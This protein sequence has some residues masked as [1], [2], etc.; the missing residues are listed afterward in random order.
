[1]RESDLM[2]QVIKLLYPVC[3]LYRANVGTFYSQ[4]GN[5]KVKGLPK[6]FPDLFGAILADKSANGFP[7]PVYIETKVRPN[8]PTPEQTAF[9]EAHRAGGCCAGVCYNVSEAWRLIRPFIKK[10]LDV[11]PDEVLDRWEKLS[12]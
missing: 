7:V 4:D 3:R 5:R 10:D 8:K 11:Y 2:N 12:G 6:G 1:M 9:I